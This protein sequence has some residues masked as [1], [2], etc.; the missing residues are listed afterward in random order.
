MIFILFAK[1]LEMSAIRPYVCLSGWLLAR[2][3]IGAIV[4]RYLYGTDI[5]ASNEVRI[6]NSQPSAS[7]CCD[8]TRKWV[9]RSVYRI[10]LHYSL[11][12]STVSYRLPER[13]KYVNGG[14]IIKWTVQLSLMQWSG[15]FVR[16]IDFCVDD[17]RTAYVISVF[18]SGFLGSDVLPGRQV[19]TFRRKQL[20]PS[21]STLEMEVTC[22]SETLVLAYPS[23]TSQKIGNLI[24]VAVRTSNLM[25][26]ALRV[27]PFG[28]SALKME[29]A[30]FSEILIPI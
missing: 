21:S 22:S 29:A 18:F 14:L 30:C 4:V 28:P 8:L 3:K 26:T 9:A 23:F 10:P 1:S 24:F 19:L 20:S 13:R 27:W 12:K 11:G 2:C 6:K 5:T 7:R 17:F 15:S 25:W 16:F